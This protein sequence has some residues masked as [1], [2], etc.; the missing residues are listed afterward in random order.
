MNNV[1]IRSRVEAR[2]KQIKM[3][4]RSLAAQMGI[5]PQ[6][7]NGFLRGRQPISLP[8]LEKIFEILGL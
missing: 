4:Q 6:E 5:T 1:D 8:K 7:L 2:L 3:S